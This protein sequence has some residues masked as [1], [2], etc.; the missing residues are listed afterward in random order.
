LQNLVGMV[1]FWSMDWSVSSLYRSLTFVLMETRRK[2]NI[3]EVCSTVSINRI[4]SLGD[5]P[6]ILVVLNNASLYFGYDMV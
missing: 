3:C 2:K 1:R 6:F 5:L 4:V